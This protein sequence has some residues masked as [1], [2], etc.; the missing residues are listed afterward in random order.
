MGIDKTGFR[1]GAEK[2]VF[3]SDEILCRTLDL[4][5]LYPMLSNLLLIRNLVSK[6]RLPC[7]EQTQQMPC[8]Y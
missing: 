8:Y 3:P 5:Y 6:P 2:R 1:Y 4:Q 7:L